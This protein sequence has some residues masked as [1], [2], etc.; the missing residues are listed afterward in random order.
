L[1]NDPFI[2][3]NYPV[4]CLPKKAG[5]RIGRKK[6]GMAGSENPIVD[7]QKIAHLKK[8]E[9]NGAGTGIKEYGKCKVWTLSAPPM[10]LHFRV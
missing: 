2:Y 9:Q 8:G 3:I 6:G 10:T 5:P 7:P 4:G 1:N